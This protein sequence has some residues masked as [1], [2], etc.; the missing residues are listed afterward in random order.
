MINLE[1]STITNEIVSKVVLFTQEL[2]LI[3][4][5]SK[6]CSETLNPHFY[7]KKFEEEFKAFLAF[8]KKDSF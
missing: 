7:G 1:A 6:L 8:Y 2:I 4:L 5:I 3:S